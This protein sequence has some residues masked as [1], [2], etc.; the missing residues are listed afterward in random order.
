[1][2]GAGYQ[3]QLGLVIALVASVCSAFCAVLNRSLKAV[4]L[5]IIVFYHCLGGMVISVL[6]ILIEA[7]MNNSGSGLRIFSYTGRMYAICG[8][9]SALDNLCLYL[10]IIA[11]T[12]DTSGFVSLLSYTRIVWAYLTDILVFDQELKV[13][14]LVAALVILCV[15]ISVALYK[16]LHTK[17]NEE[18]IIAQ[19]D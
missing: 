16:L 10:F 13:S 5:N 8:I 3:T 12:A 7:W 18:A 19:K 6:Y 17:K 15:A 9:S 1:M 4:P 2:S 14:Q 11:F